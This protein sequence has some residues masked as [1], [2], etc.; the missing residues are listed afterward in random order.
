MSSNASPGMNLRAARFTNHS[1]GPRS[2]IHRFSEMAS[3]TLRMT[4]M[5]S[6]LHRPL[7]FLI[8]ALISAGSANRSAGRAT[9]CS[10]FSIVTTRSC[11]ITFMRLVNA[12]M[13]P[14]TLRKSPGSATTGTAPAAEFT[15]V[16]VRTSSPESLSK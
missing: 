13:M 16:S 7:Y 8:S 6:I 9:L 5:P 4:P 1:L 10:T 3:S 15:V 11:P 14:S 2:R 12:S